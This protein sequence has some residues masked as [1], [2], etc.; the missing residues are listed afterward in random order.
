MKNQNP[1]PPEYSIEEL[2][3]LTTL[4][5]D[6]KNTPALKLRTLL[7]NTGYIDFLVK[8]TLDT[9]YLKMLYGPLDQIDTNDEHG[10]TDTIINWRK[11]LE[12]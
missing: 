12:K 1:K 11:S 9:N 2:K 10:I 6:L 3:E 4:L 5:N 7:Y 8:D